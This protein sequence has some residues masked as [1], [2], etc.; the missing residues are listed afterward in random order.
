MHF[1]TTSLLALLPSTV[2]SSVLPVARAPSAPTRTIIPSTSFDSQSAFD[3]DWDYLYPWGSDHNGAARM[4]KAQVSISNSVLTLTAKPVTGQPDATFAGKPLAIHYLS[5]AI[6][7]KESFTV[8]KTG[9]FDFNAEFIAPVAKG[10][11]PAF[12]L[13]AVSGWPPEIDLAEWKGS[14]LISF[15]TFN[16][17]SV[18]AA[19]DVAYPSPTA[20]HSVKVQ[21]RAESNGADVSVA[22]YLDGKL[23]TTQYG[24]G[25]V[26]KAMWL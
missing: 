14:G 17:S 16:T 5:G 18:V 9:G 22:F 2:L 8:A 1:L 12:W 10:T 20:W 19:K 26:G 13:T 24:V 6:H 7:S 15:N 3:T 21:V 25:Y 11:W 23:V 4:D